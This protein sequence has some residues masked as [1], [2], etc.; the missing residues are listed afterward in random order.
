MSSE[1]QKPS[2]PPPPPDAGHLPMGE[3]MD[4][5][6]RTLPPVLP[7]LAAAIVLAVLVGIYS[8]QA[9]K[10]G[11]TGTITR[12]AAVALPEDKVLVVVH[13]KVENLVDKPLV[14]HNAKARLEVASGSETGMLEDEAASVVDHDRYFQAFPDL[15][16]YR[17]AP[18]RME[19][20][21]APGA[22]Q[23]GMLVF[24]FPVTRESF[25]QRKAFTVM[26]D[27][28]DRRPLTLVEKKP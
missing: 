8:R 20:R 17:I 19:E 23:E 25:D 16:T 9:A 14:L 6:R 10:P 21:I 11:T 7:V 1:P 4:S 15:A 22:T 2:A 26:L 27:L 28:Y 3:E 18:L 13:V 24:A 5:A 12:V